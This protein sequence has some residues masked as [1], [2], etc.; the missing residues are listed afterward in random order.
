MTHTTTGAN[1]DT[2]PPRNERVSVA[3][4]QTVEFA[5]PDHP[6]CSDETV[7][8]LALESL[9][10]DLADLGNATVEHLFETTHRQLD[11]RHGGDDE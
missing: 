1:T 2:D 10:H 6:D 8:Q 4:D 3:F 7:E 11:H 9:L 5:V